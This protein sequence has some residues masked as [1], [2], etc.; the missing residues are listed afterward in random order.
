MDWDSDLMRDGI[1][2]LCR[3]LMEGEVSEQSGQGSV[4]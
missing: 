1:V 2:L 3:L 4:T